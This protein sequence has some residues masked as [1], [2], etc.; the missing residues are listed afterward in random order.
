MSGL[1]DNT[2]DSWGYCGWW[3]FYFEVDDTSNSNI[4]WIM[5]DGDWS[6]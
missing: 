2:S 3:R 4:G 6:L 5:N 1:T